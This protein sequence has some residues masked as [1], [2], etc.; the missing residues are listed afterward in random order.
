M[1]PRALPIGA[2]RP[3][4]VSVHW[5]R[6]Q[7][8]LRAGGRPSILGDGLLERARATSLALLGATAAVGLAIMAL[9]FNQGWPLIAGSSIPRIQPR[10]QSIADA[11]VA[12]AAG[13]A[14]SP[15]G[16]G[17]D[18]SSRHRRG[19]VGAPAS[20]PGT[21]SVP[22]AELVVSPST[23]VDTRGPSHSSPA[24][25][26]HAP[27]AQQPVQQAPAA[28]A[29]PTPAPAPA[30]PQPEAAPAPAPVSAPVPVPAPAPPQ[31]TASETPPEEESNLPPWS[32]GRGHGYGRS[33]DWHDHGWGDD[34][35]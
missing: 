13:N 12:A 25:H 33:E 21:A 35:D 7:G 17:R 18:R 31:A 26:G 6:G 19:A 22:S 15:G 9:A 23:P 20:G 14:Q 1:P 3:I 16:G 2:L 5:K 30:A 29:S 10:H 32:H 28:P 24:P 34:G 11:A 27:A 8:W 4:D